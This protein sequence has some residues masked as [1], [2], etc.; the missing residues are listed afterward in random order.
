MHA[1]IARSAACLLALLGQLC[2]EHLRYKLVHCYLP[3]HSVLHNHVP[4]L[5]MLLY[6]RAWVFLQTDLHKRRKQ[7]VIETGPLPDE[8][9]AAAASSSKPGTPAKGRG[10]AAH[11]QQQQQQQ[12]QGQQDK[13]QWDGQSLKDLVK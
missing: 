13:E 6:C 12:Q 9:A 11:N 8:S 3:L 7:L 4:A 2:L 10:R 1:S 5:F